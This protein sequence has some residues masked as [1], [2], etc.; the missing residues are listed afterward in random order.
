VIIPTYN[1]A[2]FIG[3]AIQS[4]LSQTYT[5]YEL[6]VVDDGSTDETAQVVA[7]FGE[8]VKYVY[9]DNA[10]RSSARN[11]GIA[12]AQG[13]LL[14]FLDS[15]DRMLLN[16]L[17]SLVTLLDER[18][19]VS[20]AY[21][22]YYWMDQDGQPLMWE[23]PEIEGD[24]F[25]EHASPV[26]PWPGVFLPPS[27]PTLE[28][29][30]FSRLALEE[31]MMIGSALFRRE[32]VEAVG[33]FIPNMGYQ[34]HWDFYLR[35]AGSGYI[36]ACCKKPVVM[37]RL[38]ANSAANNREEM[39]AGRID[40]LNRLFTDPS[41]ESVS[42][43]VY[44][45]ACCKAYIEF[46]EIYYGDR[47]FDKGAECL[48]K[49][50]NYDSLHSDDLAMISKWMINYPYKAIELDSDD[51]EACLREIL[52]PLF[53]SLDKGDQLQS[54]LLGRLHVVLAFQ[55]YEA[56]HRAQVV[57]RV[58]QGLRYD[59]GWLRN[60]GVSSIFAKS[61]LGQTLSSGG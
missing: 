22:W 1:R 61:L 56:G 53:F 57:R 25:A 13:E 51:P 28:G 10:G 5:D 15:D 6:I 58:I 60:R 47:D 14:S 26:S 8:R 2:D 9:Q 29:R 7:Q 34:E 27:G 18:P 24:G 52:S 21:G 23:A 3:E 19:E 50:L 49:A 40:V 41:M 44:Q 12:V 17:E 39:L 11:A 37:L 45:R 33:G 16:N 38:H 48:N 30:I 31:T 59:P 43:S 54:R 46:A 32:C 20:V 35:V 42:E 4:V 55:A 36:Y